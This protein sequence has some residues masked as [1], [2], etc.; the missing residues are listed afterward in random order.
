VRRGKRVDVTDSWDA[1][2]WFTLY[3]LVGLSRHADHHAFATRPYQQLRYWEE[4]PKLPTGYFGMVTMVFVQNERFR[5]LMTA[6]LR[7]RKLGPFA[8][9]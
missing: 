7:R 8:E 9:A 5:R 2:S 3:T 6:E 4:S 1:D